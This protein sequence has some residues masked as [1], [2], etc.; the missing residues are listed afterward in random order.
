MTTIAEK[1]CGYIHT[2][3]ICLL[4]L[5]MPFFKI[6]STICI[7]LL[8]VNS[9]FLI[10][11]VNDGIKIT[12]RYFLTIALLYVVYIIGIFNSEN[13]SAANFDVQ[14]KLSLIVL[15]IVFLLAPKL[16]ASELKKIFYCFT[17]GCFISSVACLSIAAKRYISEGSGVFFYNSLSFFLH[18]SY[19]AM[20]ITLA[21]S[22][23][24]YEIF[25]EHASL[26]LTWIRIVLI[27]YFLGFL[28]LLSSKAGLITMSLILFGTLIISYLRS[29]DKL[30]LGIMGG[31]VGGLLLFIFFMPGNMNRYLSFAK[32]ISH[33][34]VAVDT[35]ESTSERFYVWK[36]GWQLIKQHPV[37]G[38]G[39]GDVKDVLVNQYEKNGFVFGV[40][41]KLNAHN[42]FMQTMLAIGMAGIALLLF[43][44][45]FPIG[46][47][48]NTGS[49]IGFVF[50]IIVAINFMVESMLE[51]QA[52]VVFFALFY[53]ILVIDNS[54]KVVSV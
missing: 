10:K 27:S 25:I 37:L 7:V 33:D 36:N 48:K 11:K 3:L 12:N 18:P 34:K 24:L 4:M 52:G 22:F 28:F 40:E 6:M 44:L 43:C 1:Y 42:Q 54:K 35:G 20:Y 30:L 47:F 38:Y 17:A 41:R 51:T 50:L 49:F 23:L 39:T 31:A 5:V 29:G 21:V 53:S 8:F 14:L 2:F 19:F 45:I 15:P 9:F 46:L 16:S 32:I 13:I 26:R